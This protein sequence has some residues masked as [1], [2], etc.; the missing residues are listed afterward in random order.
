ME[1]TLE[2]SASPVTR[3][4][5]TKPPL[6]I[7]LVEDSPEDEIL[8]AREL[9]KAGVFSETVRVETAADLERAL[10]AGVDLVISDFNL[11]AFDAFGALTVVQ[12]SGYDLPLIVLSGAVGQVTAVDLMRSG[13]KDVISKG[14]W[15]RLLPAIQRELIEAQNRQDNRER[16]AAAHLLGQLGFLLGRSLEASSMADQAAELTAYFFESGC[17]I[18]LKDGSSEESVV[19]TG[20]KSYS[21]IVFKELLIARNEPLGELIYR[22]DRGFSPNDFQTAHEICSRISLALDNVRLL[23]SAQ[24]AIVLRDEFLSIASHEL[25]TPITAM[26]M[27]AQIRNRRL[28]QGNHSYFTPER[29]KKMMTDDLRQLDR[30]SH[31]I[32]EMMDISHIRAG[33]LNLYPELFDLAGF[34]RECVQRLQEL[35]SAQ[36]VTITVEGP[37]SLLGS[38]DAGRIEQVITNL[39]T[40]ALKYGGGTPV[41]V[42]LADEE[43]NV[44]I[45]IADQGPGI[46]P[47]GQAK[48][49]ERFQRLQPTS[50]AR[51]LGLGLYIVRQIVEAHGGKIS[52]ISQ[53][54]AG[55]S[56]TVR[57]PR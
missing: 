56:F 43:K 2:H 45:T 11:P 30:L 37:D 16:V 27:Q 29:M 42:S 15:P 4:P 6:K 9:R 33:Q 22:R 28:D 38:W 23:Q 35:P 54:G 48:I 17:E 25:K 20:T 50:A 52:L 34:T 18:R 53:V 51:G 24:Q 21:N 13:A 12:E 19:S 32:D 3:A 7:V 31:L 14:E 26:R 55:A 10:Q 5:A 47:E 1:K 8:L 41:T 44:A 36:N 49:F 39:I 57:M 46:S 40:N